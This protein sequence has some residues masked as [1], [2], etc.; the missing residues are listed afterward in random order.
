MTTRPQRPALQASGLAVALLAALQLPQALAQD[1]SAPESARQGGIDYGFL[2]ERLEWQDADDGSALHW[3]LNGWVGGDVDRLELRSE[4]ERVDGHTEEAELQL[5]WSHAL[6]SQWSTVAGAR[7]DLK[8]GAPQTWAALGVRG[9]LLDD[10]ETEATA[11]LGEAGQSAARLS[12]DYD[13]ELTDRL[14]LQ[15]LAEV[16]LY[17][18]DDEERGVGSG[19][20]EAELALLLRYEV[21]REFAPYLGVNWTRAYGD[22]ADLLREED[23]DVSETSLVAG[24]RFQF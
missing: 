11:F 4:G 7:Q 13:L 21:C 24:V 8:P 10:L 22:T 12:V 18:Q 23:E 16:N 17:G 3:D 2:A 9:E 6:N 5:L 20:A 1:A 19:L 14:V 15:P